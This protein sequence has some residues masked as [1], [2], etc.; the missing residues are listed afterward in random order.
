MKNNKFYNLLSVILCFVIVISN[1]QIVAFS[2]GYGTVSKVTYANVTRVF[3]GETFE[4]QDINTGEYYLV[5]MMGVDANAYDQ[6]Y[7]YTYNRLMG[8]KVELILHNSTI[9]KEGRWNY[10]YVMENNELVNSKIIE[11]GYATADKSLPSGS[12]SYENYVNIEND[13]QNNNVGIWQDEGLYSSYNQVTSNIYYSQNSININTASKDQLT[14]LYDVSS[15]LANNIISHRSDNPFNTVSDIKFVDGMTKSIYDQNVDYMHVVT[16]I[17]RAYEY[18]LSTLKNISESEAEDI[19]E[20][21]NKVDRYISVDNLLNQEL[22]SSTEYEDNKPFITE[23]NE[24]R[25]T[26]TE[27]EYSANINTASRTQLIEAGLSSSDASGVIEILNN[28]YNIKTIGELEHSKNVSLSED[29]LLELLDNLKVSTDINYSNQSELQSLYLDTYGVYA[30]VISSI[31]KN[32]YYNDFSELKYVISDYNFNKIQQNIYIDKDITE[33]T[34]INTATHDQL[35]NVGM[36]SDYANQIIEYRKEK[37]I[38]D[39]DRIPVNIQAYD[40]KISLYTNINNASFKEL[41]TL[42][43]NMTSNIANQIIAYVYDQPF[44]SKDEVYTFFEDMNQTDLYYI[45]EDYI[46]LY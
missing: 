14:D 18:E 5:R 12:Y 31:I 23:N 37:E 11:L 16:D 19:I 24:H 1:S 34:N 27:G 20:Y 39:Y 40:D 29:E 7:Q 35:V 41:Q 36:S 45:I 42:S 10:C 15:S 25:I 8:K 3:D 17:N 22:I 43:P 33:Y 6:A 9:H 21:R 28:G 30:N 13:A 46:V 38:L 44:G 32:R 2:A 26:L 4:A